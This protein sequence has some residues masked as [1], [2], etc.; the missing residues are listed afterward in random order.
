MGM[1]GVA[2]FGWEIEI[3]IPAFAGMTGWAAGMTGLGAWAP[4]FAGDSG[5]GGG[6][7]LRGGFGWARGD[8]DGRGLLT[9][10]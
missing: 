2:G 6:P 1:V 9:S 3:E 10:S 5:W 8:G 7:R 4:A